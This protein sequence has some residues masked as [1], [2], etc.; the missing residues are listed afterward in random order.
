MSKII[1][2]KLHANWFFIERMPPKIPKSSHK[3]CFSISIPQR[4]IMFSTITYSNGIL[5]EEEASAKELSSDRPQKRLA[6]LECRARKVCP[7]TPCGT[8]GKATGN[9]RLRKS[10][11]MYGRKGRMSEMSGEQDS[12]RVSRQQQAW[13]AQTH[14]WINR[15]R[16]RS[17]TQLLGQQQGRQRPF[18]SSWSP[19]PPFHSSLFRLLSNTEL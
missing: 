2:D 18:I 4:S 19:I 3:I 14:M 5:E 16:T 17:Q 15:R 13:S 9:W 7:F 12:L 10:G 8:R 11:Q 6:C 1:S